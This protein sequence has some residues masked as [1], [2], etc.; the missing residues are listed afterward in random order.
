MAKTN[1]E[2]TY[3]NQKDATWEGMPPLIRVC[4]KHKD[5][6]FRDNDKVLVSTEKECYFCKAHSPTAAE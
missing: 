2:Y 5:Q 3:N 4:Q 1:E 6:Y